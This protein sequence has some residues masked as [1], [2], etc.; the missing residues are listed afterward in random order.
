MGIS[1]A[2]LTNYQRVNL[3][4]PMVFPRFS[5]GCPMV[6]L[7]FTIL[8]TGGY[9]L[10][11]LQNGG[12]WASTSLGAPQEYDAKSLGFHKLEG[13]TAIKIQTVRS[14]LLGVFRVDPNMDD[15]QK[16]SMP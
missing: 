10:K 6:F 11:N 12:L 2:I 4:F 15:G 1:I 14:G 7:W 5:Y 16:S 8:S 9:G 13:V 3:H